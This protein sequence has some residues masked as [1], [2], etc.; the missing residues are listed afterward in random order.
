MMFTLT[1]TLTPEAKDRLLEELSKV[2]SFE[3]RR[4]YRRILSLSE[5]STKVA[6][7]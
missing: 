7:P 2:E 3:L 4:L 5:T 1:M 6:D